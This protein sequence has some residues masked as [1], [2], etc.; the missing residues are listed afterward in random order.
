MLGE[1][2]PFLTVPLSALSIKKVNRLLYN[3]LS[4][5]QA[6]LLSITDNSIKLDN[7]GVSELRHDGCLLQELDFTGLI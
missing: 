6:H 1:G 2:L 5:A 4:I 3:A 7:I